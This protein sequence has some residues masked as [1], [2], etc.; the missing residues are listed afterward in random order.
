M[1]GSFC[2]IDDRPRV[3]SPGDIEILSELAAAA[4]DVVALRSEAVAAGDAGRRLQRALVPEPGELPGAIA[5]A[6]YRPGEQRS[7]LGGDFFLCEA[8][9][10][11]TIALLDRRRRRPRPGGGGVRDV[12]ALHLA[13]AAARAVRRSRSSVERG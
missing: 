6:V 8:L 12:A 1:L 9:R 4:T 5:S 10:D 13:G 11:G 3:W 7:L 2:V